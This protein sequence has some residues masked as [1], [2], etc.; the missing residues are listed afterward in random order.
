MLFADV[1]CEF[2]ILPTP[3]WLL[4]VGFKN[5][6]HLCLQLV[7]RVD[8]EVNFLFLGHFEKG[9]PNFV[10]AKSIA[11]PNYDE[12]ILRTSEGNIDSSLIC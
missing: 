9:V 7:S 2:I 1:T 8:F 3:N 4:V 11:V 10:S 6:L 12:H 5:M